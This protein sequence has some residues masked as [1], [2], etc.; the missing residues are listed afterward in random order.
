[1]NDMSLKAKIRNIAS[2]KN[3]SA[4]AVL[5]NYLMCRFLFRLAKSEYK[6]KFVIKGGMLISSIIGVDQRSTLDLDATIRNMQ[7][8]E[9]IIREAFIDI[10]SVEAG[11]GI[12]FTFKSIDPIRADDEYGGYRVLYTAVLGKI[13]APMSMDISTGDV[14]TPEA[15]L[16][17]FK[18]M[19][20][21]EQK[22]KLFSYPI[23]TVIAEKLETILSRGIDNTRLRDFYDVYMLSAVNY[24]TETLREAFIATS[25]HR[26]S[27]D[28]TRNH[29]EI[30][31]AIRSDSVMNQRWNGYRKQM[32][33]AEAIN[34]AETL[35]AM[36]RIMD[37]IEA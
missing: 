11:D 27:F 33:Y 24:D 4:A 37:T 18:D 2:D 21:P 16:H 3:I 28:K 5:Q 7:L 20:D 36:N 30:I 32:K 1:M 26:G 17:E 29:T 34:F 13:N 9:A 35:D 10:C 14:I 8:E 22:I 19:F 25:K 31:N 23:E 15:Q 6:N 12:Q